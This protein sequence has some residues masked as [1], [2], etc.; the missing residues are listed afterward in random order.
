MSRIIFMGTPDFAVPVLDALT[1]TTHKIVGVY[2]RPDKPAGRGN[3]LQISPIKRLAESRGLAIFQPKS[4]RH[5]D[6]IA[7]L[8]TL[9]PD[10]IIVA[11]YGLI[12]PPDV[13][14]IPP[15]G[16]VNTH[17]SLLPKYRGAAP[18]SAAILAGDKET[19]ITLMQMEAGLD[20]GPILAQRFVAIADDDTTATLTAKLANVA[21]A[22]M[23]EKLPA[24]LAG[25]ITPLPQD[26]SQATI[27]KTI[28]K[29]EGLIDWNISALEI[30]RRVRAFNPWPSAFTFWNGVQLKI[31]NAQPSTH[32][33]AA[34]P[35]QVIAWGKEIGVATGDGLLALRE[36]QL[37]GKRAMKI[38][39]FVRGQKEFVGGKLDSPIV[40]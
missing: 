5:P 33:I 17:A 20:T 14:S 10:V 40:R 35:G 36:V 26:H 9:A 15:R 2:T 18:I 23:I 32:E 38:E 28:H 29:E 11:A 8:R 27:V 25:E 19:G 6:A 30:S 22:L 24:I 21:A 39:E 1:Q 13:L 16:C 3:K 34:E 12:L 7:E 37:A 4:L 31:L